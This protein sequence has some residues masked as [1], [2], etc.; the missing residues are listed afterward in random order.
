MEQAYKSRRNRA[1]WV[2]EAGKRFVK[3]IFSDAAAYERELEIYRLLEATDLPCAKV[4][5]AQGQT[6]LLSHLPGQTLVELLERQE[7]T[8]I[9]QWALWEQLTDWLTEFTRRTGFV[10]TDVNLRNFLYDGK[11]L[12]GLDF[13]ECEPGESAGAIAGVAAFIRL[14]RPE[15]TPLKRQISQY[16]LERFARNCDKEVE[17]LLAESARREEALLQRRRQN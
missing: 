17:W 1:A 15:H 8:G 14:Y 2:E 16:I 7:E 12:Y 13:E 6:L 10:M 3:K 11:T 4:L 5:E 9:I